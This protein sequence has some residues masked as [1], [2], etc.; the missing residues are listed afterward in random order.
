[1]S[2]TI[3]HVAEAS[4][5]RARQVRRSPAGAAGSAA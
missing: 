5:H 2:D 4:A 1:M 3:A